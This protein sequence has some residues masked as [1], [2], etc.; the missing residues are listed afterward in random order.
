MVVI[1]VG[2]LAY[3]FTTTTTSTEVLLSFTTDLTSVVCVF[4]YVTIKKMSQAPIVCIWL[5]T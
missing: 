4:L 3:F 1:I 5:N 2:P